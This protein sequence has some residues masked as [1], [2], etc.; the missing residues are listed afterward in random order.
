MTFI[1]LN[2]RT[3]LIVHGFDEKNKEI[4]ET[5]NEQQYTK[6]LI[7]LE[8]IRSVSEQFVLVTSSHGRMM[9]WEYDCEFAKLQKRLTENGLLITV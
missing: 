6:K 3:A 2:V 4:T 9:Y 8:R 7:A 1:E 5:V